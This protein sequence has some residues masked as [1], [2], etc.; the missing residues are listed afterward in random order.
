[1]ARIIARYDERILNTMVR[2]GELEPVLHAELLRILIGRRRALLGRYLARL[3]ALADPELVARDGRAWLC[4]TDLAVSTGVMRAG[5]YVTS[6]WRGAELHPV[7]APGAESTVPGRVCVLLPALPAPRE[8]PSYFLI[9]IAH[10]GPAPRPFPARFH[11]YHYGLLNYR[12]VGM[13][14]PESFAAPG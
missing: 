11:I 9:E 6:A 14:R 8:R 3:S 2:A 1:M 5:R 7:V 4:V 12:L 10:A 13:E